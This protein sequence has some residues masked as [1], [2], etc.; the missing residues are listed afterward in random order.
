MSK[1]TKTTLTVLSIFALLNVLFVPI[2]DVWGGLFPSDV[3]YNFADVIEDI[4]EDPDAWRHW[5]VVLTM[6]IFI[7]TLIMFIM[8]LTGK[9]GLFI[10]ANAI[11]IGIWL[12]QI[13]DY[14]MED[15]GFEDL[16]DFEDGCVSIGTWI[17]IILY[18]ICFIVAI[19]SKRKTNYQPQYSTVSNMPTITDTYTKNDTTL[20]EQINSITKCPNCGVEISANTLFCGS[21]GQRIE[22]SESKAPIKQKNF[23]P[24]CGTEITEQASFCGKCGYKF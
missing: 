11:G 8:S 10:T 18:L 24:Q 6:S 14:G 4:F 3:E 22:N 21:C 16:L 12:K 13:I 23:C 17:A 5:V 1:S 2:F 7:P 19:S 9:K 15:D 20:P